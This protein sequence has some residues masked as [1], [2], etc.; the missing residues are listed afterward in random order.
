[1]ETDR[2]PIICQATYHMLSIIGNETNIDPAFTESLRR[3]RQTVNRTL[4]VTN[5][6]YC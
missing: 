1:M 2:I 4:K 5:K 6:V 3:G